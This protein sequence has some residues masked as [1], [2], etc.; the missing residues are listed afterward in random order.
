MGMLLRD[1]LYGEITEECVRL[2]WFWCADVDVC[3]R[4]DPQ[5]DTDVQQTQ[6]LQ[7]AGKHP[8]Q[9]G[10]L[11]EGSGRVPGD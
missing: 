10:R 11:R 3:S 4:K 2:C 9:A 1:S 8:E 5:R 7:R 6:P